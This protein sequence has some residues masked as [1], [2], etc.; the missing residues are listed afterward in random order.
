MIDYVI[1]L[2]LEGEMRFMLI[3]I[4]CFYNEQKVGCPITMLFYSEKLQECIS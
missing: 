2:L 4:L 1:Y 3:Y